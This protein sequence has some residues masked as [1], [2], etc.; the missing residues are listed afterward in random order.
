MIW[1][2]S[3]LLSESIVIA[4]I[5]VTSDD[6]VP[7]DAS[8]SEKQYLNDP[9]HYARGGARVESVILHTV[10]GSPLVKSSENPQTRRFSIK[11]CYP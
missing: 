4:I 10:G 11:E 2:L 5:N 3:S 8:P 1:R 7:Y 6:E 9:E